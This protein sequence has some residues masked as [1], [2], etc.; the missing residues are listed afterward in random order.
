MRFVGGERPVGDAS[1]SAL[2]NGCAVWVL[3]PLLL[4]LLAEWDPCPPI[5]V[6]SLAGVARVSQLQGVPFARTGRRVGSHPLC[7]ARAGG[8]ALAPLSTV[9]CVRLRAGPKNAKSFVPRVQD[10]SVTCQDQTTVENRAC[11][12]RRSLWVLRVSSVIKCH[13]PCFFCT[14]A[15]I[16][17]FRV[18]LFRRVINTWCAISCV[19][20]REAAARGVTISR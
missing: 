1:V 3:G 6:P 2:C 8:L 16:A 11:A 14:C 17:C 20:P 7:A 5:A 13:V 18:V 9:R 15:L 19:A 4:G 12:C 10:R